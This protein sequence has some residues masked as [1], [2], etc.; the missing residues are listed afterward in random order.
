VVVGVWSGGNLPGV[1]AWDLDTGKRTFD[2]NDAQN[3]VVSPVGHGA[4]LLDPDVRTIDLLT[5]RVGPTIPL[6]VRNATG[7][8]SPDGKLLAV[9]A[10]GTW[11]TLV[12]VER[13]VVR[14]LEDSEDVTSAVFSG[15]GRLLYG[16]ASDGIGVWRVVDGAAL[17]RANPLGAATLLRGRDGKLELVGDA[18]AGREALACSG[19]GRVHPFA[20]CDPSIESPG[21]ISR[22]LRAPLR[23]PWL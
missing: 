3:V 13:G 17:W 1:V 19:G 9:G 16:R 10:W 12:D 4:V 7:A 15:D 20:G 21:V 18:S 6:P 2:R 23:R 8:I 14:V 22:A 5:G 11:T